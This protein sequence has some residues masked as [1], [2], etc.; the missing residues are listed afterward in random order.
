MLSRPNM[1][2]CFFAVFDPHSLLTVKI[3]SSWNWR[4]RAALTLETPLPQFV[5]DLAYELSLLHCHAATDKILTDT[6]TTILEYQKIPISRQRLDRLRI[7]ILKIL[8]VGSR[9][10]QKLSSGNVFQKPTHRCRQK[11]V[12]WRRL[13]FLNLPAVKNWK[14]SKKCDWRPPS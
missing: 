7:Q 2:F 12:W 3:S 6:S 9:Q 13:G 14:L 1:T 11:L 4:W 5:L 8:H 10:L